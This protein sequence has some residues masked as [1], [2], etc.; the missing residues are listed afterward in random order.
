MANKEVEKY[1]QEAINNIRTDRAVTSKLLIEIMNYI[2]GK[3]ERHQEVGA[4][5]AKYVETLQRSNE[6]LVKVVA[7][8]QKKDNSQTGLSADDKEEL[9]DLIKEA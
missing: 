7:L 2:G 5:A 9:F 3:D 6:Q 1:L 8:L 4:V